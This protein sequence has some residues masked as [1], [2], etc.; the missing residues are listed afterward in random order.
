MV[1]IPNIL[2]V[3]FTTLISL[4]LPLL[5]LLVFGL[6][7]RKQGI[8][9]A[10]LLGAAGF[11]ATQIVIRASILNALS[12]QNWFVEFSQKHIL[13]YGFSLA[14]TAGLFE[15]AG[16]YA[17]ARIMDKKLTCRRAIAAGLGHGGIEAMVIIGMTYV[18]NLIYII[19]INSGGFDALI[20]QSAAAGVGP[21][22]LEAIRTALVST[23]PALFLLAGFERIL[24]MTGHL[25]M[26][27][28]VCWGVSHKK[29]L[30]ALLGCLGLHTFLDFTGVVSLLPGISQT[31][32]YTII[33]VILT[34]MAVISILI[35]RNLIRCWREKEV[36]YV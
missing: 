28:L 18:N 9:S 1:P 8:V 31:T 10:W 16:R 27:M 15:L 34:I 25:A 11:L 17:A 35:I 5:L 29:T 32:A 19:L 4:I 13:L 22:Q 20:A 30:P 33:Y 14:F 7:Y 21:A 23:S 26:S 12:V 24:A 6:K 2:A 3:G 36:S